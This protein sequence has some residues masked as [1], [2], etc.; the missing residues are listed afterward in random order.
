MQDERNAAADVPFV[1][2]LAVPAAQLREDAQLPANV[3]APILPPAAEQ[4]IDNS[5]VSRSDL[6]QML[7]TFTG[8]VATDCGTLIQKQ[9]IM[10]STWVDPNL[11]FLS[12]MVQ[13]VTSVGTGTSRCIMVRPT[14]HDLSSYVKHAWMGR[15]IVHCSETSNPPF[16]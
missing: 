11:Q 4:K 6:E 7:A 13:T 10:G 5:P 2:V 8:K 1:A 12:S 16:S 3:L 9:M 14:P 15:A